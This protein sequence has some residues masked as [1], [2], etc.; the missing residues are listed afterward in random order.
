M[1]VI[2][3]RGLL[4]DNCRFEGT[5]GTAPQAGID[6]EPNTAV[7][8]VSD[9]RISNSVFFNNT[10]SCVDVS[11]YALA[12]ATT[13]PSISLSSCHCVLA[14]E[15]GF[16]IEVPLQQRGSISIMDTVV[17]DT[18]LP[19]LS[20]DRDSG[21]SSVVLSN[22]TF[23]NTSCGDAVTPP[24]LLASN[25]NAVRLQD[26]TVVDTVAR[27]FVEVKGDMTAGRA[28]GGT[29]NVYGPDPSINCVP[30]A[31]SAMVGALTVK[32]C[33]RV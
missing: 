31:P 4:V 15:A 1:S 30:D 18:L 5:N 33:V 11:L 12:N 28:I 23:R 3:V 26:V 6:F 7:E 2:S 8:S 20:M 17:E 32:T 25:V 13:P 24:L 21:G 19:G 22:V 9:V 16:A 27:A 29:F 10:G 14:G